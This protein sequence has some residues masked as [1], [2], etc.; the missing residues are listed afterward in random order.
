MHQQLPGSHALLPPM[1][2]V[3]A[4]RHP[5]QRLAGAALQVCRALPR[6]RQCAAR[7]VAG[8][9]RGMVQVGEREGGTWCVW[10]SCALL[11]ASDWTAD[12]CCCCVLGMDGACLDHSPRYQPLALC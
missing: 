6:A 3:H 9:Q 7:G 2:Q 4:A 10:W 5:R 12:I 8:P 1:L 11:P